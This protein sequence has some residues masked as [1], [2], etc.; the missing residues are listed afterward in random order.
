MFLFVSKSLCSLEHLLQD[1]TSE[2]TQAP[3]FSKPGLA[4]PPS[5]MHIVCYCCDEVRDKL[6]VDFGLWFEVG[7]AWRQ[8]SGAA[9]HTVREAGRDGI[10]VCCFVHSEMLPSRLSLT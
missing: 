2:E 6:Q 5:A 9:N 3:S 7:K 4:S 1:L 8:E 10:T